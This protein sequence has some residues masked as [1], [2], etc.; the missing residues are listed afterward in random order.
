M[1]NINDLKIS[2][3]DNL[4]NIKKDI[5]EICNAVNSYPLTKSTKNLLDLLQSIS[6][7]LKESIRE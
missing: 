1:D 5:E 2:I 4:N 6:N 3:V 7:A